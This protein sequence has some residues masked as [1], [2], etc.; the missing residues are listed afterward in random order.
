[1]GWLQAR[2]NIKLMLD[3]KNFKGHFISQVL[4]SFSKNLTMMAVIYDLCFQVDV[5]MPAFV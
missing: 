1:M 2:N 3:L 5:R 4:L